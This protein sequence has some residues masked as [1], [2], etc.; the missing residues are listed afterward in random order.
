MRTEFWYFAQAADDAA[1]MAAGDAEDVFDAGF[2]QHAADQVGDGLCLGQH[3]FYWH[4]GS[5][6]VSE[7]VH[8]IVVP[9]Q[10][11]GAIG[12]TGEADATAADCDDRVR[13]LVAVTGKN[14]RHHGNTRFGPQVGQSHD[15]CMGGTVEIDQRREKLPPHDATMLSS[16]LNR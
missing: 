2:V 11:P 15:R 3:A 7:I 4:C 16:I 8:P 5:P 9:V 10:L 6:L 13:Q 14:L 12:R 1:G